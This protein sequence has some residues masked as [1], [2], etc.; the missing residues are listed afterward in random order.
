MPSP[1]ATSASAVRFQAR[2]VRS[3]ASVN[4]ASGSRPAA[5]AAEPGPSA[6]L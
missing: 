3:L 1:A 4:R 5:G 2:N 6:S